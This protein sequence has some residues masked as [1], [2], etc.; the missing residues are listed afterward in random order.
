MICGLYVVFFSVPVTFICQ[1]NRFLGLF[2]SALS[3]H[4]LR[5]GR[6]ARWPWIM[7][8]GI[9]KNVV[10]SRHGL[11]MTAFCGVEPCS[12]VEVDRRFRGGTQPPS[13][14]QSV[15]PLPWYCTALHS[16]KLSCL[17]SLPWE[18]EIS[19][20]HGLFKYY[21]I[22]IPECNWKPTKSLT[23]ASLPAEIQIGT[24]SA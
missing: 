5:H 18:P 14:G 4:E 15:W 3:M 22:I 7:N 21:S 23:I 24:S 1:V 12:L 9:G 19:H 17:Y 16:R 2:N 11:K 10:W 6:M 8:W 13:S 20:S